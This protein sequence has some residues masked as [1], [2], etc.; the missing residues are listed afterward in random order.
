MG[1]VA[2]CCLLILLLFFSFAQTLLCAIQGRVINR[3]TNAAVSSVEVTLFRFGPAGP[4]EIAR[5]STDSDGQFQFSQAPQGNLMLR[6][7]YQGVNYHKVLMGGAGAPVVLEVYETTQVPREVEFSQH[8]LLFEP[9]SQTVTVSETLFVNNRSNTTWYDPS[10]GTIK[11]FLP[12]VRAGEVQVSVT[13]PD[14][15]PMPQALQPASQE[16]I[17]K[18]DLPVKPGETR[19]DLSYPIPAQDVFQWRLVAPA[20][21]T[22]LVVPPGVELE[23]PAVKF[24]TTEPRTQALIY[25][26]TAERIQF[27]LKGTGTL[28]ASNSQ[29]SRGPRLSR[30]PP[31]IY[32]QALYEILALSLLALATG[33]VLLYRR[34]P[35]PAASST[36][37]SPR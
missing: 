8:I 17:F 20:N 13:S 23:S 12:G 15:L 33:F 27:S 2:R 14:S 22:R 35:L 16:N 36:G 1:P 34:R 11:L 7:N 25:E 29:P 10:S 30:I 31:A 9:A 19:V 3:T 32:Q 4:E 5:T 6:V 28:R 18:L 21:R 24:L 37:S 26:P